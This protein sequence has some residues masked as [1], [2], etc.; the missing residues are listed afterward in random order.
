MEFL[1]RYLFWVCMGAAALVLLVI[2]FTSVMPVKKENKALQREIR[3]IKDRMQRWSGK[4]PEDIPSEEMINAQNKY[5]DLMIETRKDCERWY[6]EQ[7]ADFDSK[8]FEGL[9]IEPGEKTP[10]PVVYK[11]IYAKHVKELLEKYETAFGAS[12]GA[13]SFDDWG[14]GLPSVEEVRRSQKEY[15]LYETF[16]E[17]LSRNDGHGITVLSSLRFV[18]AAGGRG[19]AMAGFPG[20][21]GAAGAGVRPGFAARRAPSRGASWGEDLSGYFWLIPFELHLTM[22]VR[23]LPSLLESLLSMPRFAR[24]RT[25]SMRRTTPVEKVRGAIPEVNVTIKGDILDSLTEEEKKE[26]EKVEW[27]RERLPSW[28]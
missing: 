26:K 16:L 23:Q 4:K 18:G 14:E 22:D 1:K 8:F 19:V 24:I 12:K 3:G 17:A 6:E 9:T 20:I 13:F 2:Y 28:Y 7:E 5:R 21:P 11:E 27:G 15:W 25:V 10:S